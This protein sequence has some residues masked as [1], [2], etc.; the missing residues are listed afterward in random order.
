VRSVDVEHVQ[1]DRPAGLAHRL[2]D[3]LLRQERWRNLVER[4]HDVQQRRGGRSQLPR[5]PQPRELESSFGA[6]IREDRDEA[7]G[8]TARGA[9]QRSRVD[10]V[11]ANAADARPVSPDALFGIAIRERRDHRM[12]LR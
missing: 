7:V 9:L 11:P 6:H 2:C 10:R 4:A 3:E 5:R 8:R 12:R 1:R